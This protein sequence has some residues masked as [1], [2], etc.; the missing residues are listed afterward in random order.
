MMSLV[1]C[2]LLI[3]AA[4]FALGLAVVYVPVIVFTLCERLCQLMTAARAT[5]EQRA[6]SQV[7]MHAVR[8]SRRDAELSAR[9]RAETR[10]IR[11]NLLRE[12]GDR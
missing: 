5:P 4:M 6:R 7:F 2:L 12:L 9:L 10:A 11:E 3:A 8:R 1:L